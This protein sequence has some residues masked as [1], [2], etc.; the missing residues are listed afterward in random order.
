MITTLLLYRTFQEIIRSKTER[1]HM[2]KRAAL[3]FGVVAATCGSVTLRC[4]IVR[5][6]VRSVARAWRGVVWS[7]GVW[8]EQGRHTGH[9][10]RT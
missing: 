8:D 9:A 5:G 4:M 1:E 3:I 7:S 2:S 10:S 6:R